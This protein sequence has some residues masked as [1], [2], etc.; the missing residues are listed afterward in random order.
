VRSTRSV[1][2]SSM[3]G[4]RR[5]RAASERADSWPSTRARPRY[6]TRRRPVKSPA[7]ARH[8]R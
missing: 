8:P 5:L 2:P 3:A 1:P 4:T 7:S 6:A